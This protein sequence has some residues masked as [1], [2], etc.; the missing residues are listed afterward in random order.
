MNQ[1]SLYSLAGFFVLLLSMLACRPVIAIGWEE[2]LFLFIVIAI[3][4]GPPIYRF[5]RRVENF[6]RDKPRDKS[7]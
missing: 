1:K 6:R 4:I 3:L 5:I 7:A 2:F